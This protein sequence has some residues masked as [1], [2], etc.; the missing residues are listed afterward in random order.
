MQAIYV[1]EYAI[2]VERD[3]RTFIAYKI[4][5]QLIEY[6]FLEENFR[7][8]RNKD[9]LKSFTIKFSKKNLL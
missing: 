7:F 1:Q 3:R 4:K 8:M 2:L 9:F 5:Y 6:G